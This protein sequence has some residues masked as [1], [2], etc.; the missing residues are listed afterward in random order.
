MKLRFV[1]RLWFYFRIGYSTYLSFLL[2]FAN[3]LVVLWYLAIAQYPPIQN[4]FGHFLPFAIVT[5]LIGIPTAIGAGWLHM[6]RIPA[7]SSELDIGV[8]AN[9]YYFRSPPGYWREVL[10][11][12]FRELLLSLADKN[13]PDLE[14][15]IKIKAILEKIDTLTEGGYV[16]NPHKRF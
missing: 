6:K 12:V 13:N 3:T 14:R 9:P 11:P 8:E 4:L 7:Y 2:G 10:F 16:G 5:A 1:M 15:Q